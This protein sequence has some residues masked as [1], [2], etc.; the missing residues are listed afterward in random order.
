MTY[1]NEFKDSLIEI[2][3]NDNYKNFSVGYIIVE[4]EDNI[5]LQ[6]IHPMGFIDGKIL[7]KKN[8]IN[9]ITK[10]SSYLEE[11][12]ILMKENQKENIL[13]SYLFKESTFNNNSNSNNILDSTLIEI[14]EKNLI[15]TI[16][17][18]FDEEKNFGFI[19]NIKE[20]FIT[21]KY[22][23]EISI[24]KKEEIKEIF[25]ETISDKRDLLIDS[26]LKNKI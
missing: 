8:K 18:I 11:I 23:N 4:D 1:I 3:T 20:N 13:S 2:Y 5:L 26:N 21:I 17:S 12:K 14:M 7:I 15:C 19:E 10:N 22:Q 16:I 6:L 25:I 9:K 24:I